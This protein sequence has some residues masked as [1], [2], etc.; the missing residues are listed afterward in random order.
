MLLGIDLGTS[1]IKATLFD[2]ETGACVARERLPLTIATPRPDWAEFDPRQIWSA[3]VELLRRLRESNPRALERT[4]AIGLS[5]VFP[6]LVPMTRTGEALGPVILYCDLRS[7]PQ[8]R[9]LE[10]AFGP[11]EITRLTGNQ[12]TPGT[13]TL[14]GI[15]W[16]RKNRPDVAA[17]TEVYGQLSTYLVCRLTGEIAVDTSH[18]SLSGMAAA[19]NERHWRPEILEYA[20]LTPT[21]LPRLLA[22]CEIAGEVTPAASRECG[23]REGIPVVAGCGDAPLAALGGGVHRPGQV[24]CSAGTTD[25]LMFSADRPSGNPVFCNVKAP[26]PNLW[27]AIG[28][29]STAGGAVGWL[30]ENLLHCTP[31]EMTAWAETAHPGADGLTFLPYLRG[32]RTPWWNPAARGVFAGLSLATGRAEICRAV[33]EG[34]ACGWR[35]IL[36]L[37]ETEYGFRPPEILAV[38][39]GSTNPLWNR[40]KATILERP[41]HALSYTE[42]TS[43]GAALIAGIGAGIYPD[44]EAACRATEDL[45]ERTVFEPVPEWRH[46]SLAAYERYQALYPALEPL[47]LTQPKERTDGPPM[48]EENHG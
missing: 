47:F 14:P 20:G 5:T 30:C 46:A 13:T 31:D 32:E 12:L 36:S 22:S 17:R 15:L 8:V 34:V 21:D 25:C 27:V 7:L 29:M 38:G 18:T 43:L 44:A 9:E 11:G 45:R 1:S 19:G 40:I 37:L 35:Q 39:G 42:T 4:R 16:L 28:T 10:N 2:P 33:L 26:A 3:L 24:F 41:V 6:A 48:A 23:L